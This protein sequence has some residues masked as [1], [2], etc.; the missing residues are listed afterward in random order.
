MNERIKRVRKE[1]NLTQ[2]AFS[3]K[4]G[5]SR[6]FI[7]QTETGAKIPSDRTIKDICREF[8]INEEWLRHGVE[9]MRK[10]PDDEFAGVLD[11]LLT[12]DAPFYDHIKALL[13]TYK[14]LDDKSKQCINDFTLSFINNLKKEG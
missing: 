4:L 10:Q 13:V 9:P 1:A 14:A 8:N 11:D 3:S 2:E 6:N 12:E 7:A 5:L